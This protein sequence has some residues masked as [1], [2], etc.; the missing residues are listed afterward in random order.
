MEIGLKEKSLFRFVLI[1]R[2][3]RI[4]PVPSQAISPKLKY[5]EIIILCPH[6]HNHHVGIINIVWAEQWS[7]GASRNRKN[8]SISIPISHSLSTL[9]CRMYGTCELC[10]F[11]FVVANPGLPLPPPL[12]CVYEKEEIP[13]DRQLCEY[14]HWIIKYQHE[15]SLLL[16][17]QA[18]N[19]N[20]KW[21]NGKTEGWG[22]G[23]MTAL[24]VTFC[25]S[26]C[27]LSSHS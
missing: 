23:G 18:H 1:P 14:K 3:P 16:Y 25:L 20:P 26:G 9:I 21:R 13:K 7:C 6:Q 24:P 22:L 10:T 27:H 5:N 2:P 15:A 19:G 17:S 12:W 11:V 8:F 4:H